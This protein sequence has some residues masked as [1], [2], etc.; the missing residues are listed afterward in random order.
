MILFFKRPFALFAK[1]VILLAD[2]L[3]SGRGVCSLFISVFGAS[4]VLW[5]RG[6]GSAVV[7]AVLCGL[8]LLCAMLAPLPGLQLEMGQAWL[9]DYFAGLEQ[10]KQ[11]LKETADEGTK[12]IIE[13]QYSAYIV[14]KAKELD[15]VC[16]VRVTGRTDADGL[17]VPDGVEV[18]GRFS[19]EEQSRLA[20]IIEEELLVPPERQTYYSEEEL[21]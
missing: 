15:L 2:G 5:K 13:E 20:R 19:D 17:T 7:T 12:G 14:D 1:S 10:Q 6:I 9:E 16:Q 4:R 11:N 18:A 21:P 3:R 8:V